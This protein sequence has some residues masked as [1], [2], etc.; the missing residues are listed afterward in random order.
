MGA[1]AGGLSSL[2]LATSGVQAVSGA[3]SAYSQSRATRMQGNYIRQTAEDD[4]LMREIEAKQ[5]EKQ[6]GRA[7]A[8][9][10][11]ETQALI[12]RQRAAAAGQGVGLESESVLDM[13][14][15]AAMFGAM[16]QEAEVNNAWA[17]SWGLRADAAQTR[18]AGR[19]ARNAARFD[20]RQTA[21]TGGLAFGRDVLQ[22]VY[23]YENFRK[24]KDK[25]PEWTDKG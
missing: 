16:D 18:R 25:S 14:G 22:G 2:Y 3:A 20:A 5:A 17:R 21:A 15:D 19:N 23:G 12:G 11:K 10:G 9:R 8:L 6:G 7:A 1:S 4:A 24:A 13:T